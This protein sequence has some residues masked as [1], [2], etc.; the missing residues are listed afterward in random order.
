MKTTLAYECLTPEERFRLILAAGSRN[1]D[2]ERE[3]LAKASQPRTVS[4]S[5][6][7]PFAQA[8]L[9][10]SDFTYL[11][12][13]NLAV[14]YLDCLL[15]QKAANSNASDPA[16]IVNED[17]C[18]HLDQFLV[19]G[20]HLRTYYA[21]WELFCQQMSLPAQ[22]LWEKNPGFE[23]LQQALELCQEAALTVEGYHAWMCR[24]HSVEPPSVSSLCRVPEI[25]QQEYEETYQ[26]RKR[27]WLGMC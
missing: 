1:D 25:I 27:W 21:G 18:E 22:L 3:R 15:H 23:R 11:K 17:R 26:E 12:L 8:F 7:W 13:F 16:E 2:T 20:Y 9:E 24:R 4:M 6:H 14:T 5:D 19:L 10:L